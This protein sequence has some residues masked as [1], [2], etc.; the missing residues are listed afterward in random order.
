VPA[1]VITVAAGDGADVALCCPL[2]AVPLTRRMARAAGISVESVEAMVQRRAPLG[3][4]PESWEHL[5]RELAVRLLSARGCRSDGRR[6]AALADGDVQVAIGGSA[7]ACFSSAKT[8]LEKKHFPSNETEL[9]RMI[10]ESP[11]NAGLE[12][13]HLVTIVDAARRLYRDL[14]LGDRAPRSPWF[15]ILNVL[16]GI[17]E[18]A[19][20]DL[21]I[22]SEVIDEIMADRSA[23]DPGITHR[24]RADRLGRWDEFD[25]LNAFPELSTLLFRISRHV[26]ANFEFLGPK[27]AVVIA[28]RHDWWRI[29]D[30]HAG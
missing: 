5:Q 23:I 30:H 3:H 4:T 26:A 22:H 6:P 2:T 8:T 7:V 15:N 29:L 14:G 9:E 25:V 24:M 27:G 21:Q 13:H 11:L 28:P 18:P 10:R 17:E 20:L 19:D 12:E 1:E 16:G